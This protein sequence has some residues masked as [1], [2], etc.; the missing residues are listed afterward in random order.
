MEFELSFLVN[1]VVDA[2]PYYFKKVMTK[3]S[4]Y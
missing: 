2:F 4:F 1:D 3:N